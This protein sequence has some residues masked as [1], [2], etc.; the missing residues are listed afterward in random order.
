MDKFLEILNTIGKW[1]LTEGVQAV[2]GLLCFWIFCKI[3]NIIFRFI[4]KSLNKKPHIDPTIVKVAVVWTKRGI[5]F[6]A[7]VVMLGIIGVQTSGIT[8]AIAALGLGIGL[9]LQGSL[10]NFAGGML[11][12]ALHPYKVGDYIEFN[13]YSGTVQEI[14][15]FYTYIN[16]VDNKRIVI[17]NGAMSNSN[18]VNYSTNKT[19]RDEIKISIAYDADFTL[20]KTALLK[21]LDDEPKILKDPVPFIAI[22]EY[23]QSSILITIR[24]WSDIKDFWDIHFDMFEKIK[25]TLDTNKI[26]IPFPQ[27]DVHYKDKE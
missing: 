17:P 25:L 27:L 2:I 11:I 7:F 5:K 23:Q 26:S 9:A 1:F 12:L 24:F 13:N 14:E 19:R 8:A 21:M 6:V 4:N 18:I 10:A 22:C 15:L 16:T 3:T 20:A